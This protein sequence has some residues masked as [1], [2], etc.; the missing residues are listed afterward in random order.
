MP[1][2]VDISNSDEQALLRIGNKKQVATFFYVTINTVNAWIRRGCPVVKKGNQGEQWQFDVLAVALW[3]FDVK[4]EEER[5][6]PE[7]LEPKQRLDW[8]RGTQAKVDLEVKAAQLIPA[9]THELELAEAFKT[10]SVTL[11]SLPDMLERDAGL[12]PEAV[13]RA[14]EIVDRLRSD[15][16]DRIQRR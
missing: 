2:V 9:G 12:P 16:V 3:K 10:V 11:E 8:Y 6:D 4:S 1:V 14:T 13:E 5:L 15:L 7:D